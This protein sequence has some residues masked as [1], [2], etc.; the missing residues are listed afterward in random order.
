[1]RFNIEPTI[2]NN[3]FTNCYVM[4]APV[5]GDGSF[6]TF[7]SNTMYECRSI[8][9]NNEDANYNE[10]QYS[11][12]AYN[13]FITS[14]G[15][16]FITKNNSGLHK[17]SDIHHN[18]VIGSSSFI[19]IKP[20]YNGVEWAPNIYDNL[21]ILAEDGILFNESPTFGSGNF[22]STFKSES[23]FNNNVYLASAVSGGSAVNLN[24]YS[25]NLE[26][27]D[28]FEINAAPRFISTKPGDADEYRMRATKL[29]WVYT[30]AV[31]GYPNY[32]GA[33]EPLLAPLQTIIIIK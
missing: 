28:C 29:D 13:K 25:F 5:K 17:G 30:T 1:M 31:G 23:T 22:N 9:S 32:V 3:V 8:Q 27:T 16:P 10:L 18:T 11:E 6:Y 24:G 20:T 19:L 14:T 15:E 2:R 26:P 33:V 4:F 12:I 7:T 21:I